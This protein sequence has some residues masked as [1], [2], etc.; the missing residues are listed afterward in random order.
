VIRCALH[1]T[2]ARTRSNPICVQPMEAVQ[3]V[4]NV[5][6]NKYVNGKATSVR[7]LSGVV[8]TICGT[9]LCV[10]FGSSD[11]R[12]FDL[13]ELEAFWTRP[14]WWTYLALSYSVATAAHCVHEAY[15]RAVAAGRRPAHAMHVMP[16]TF[17]VSSALF[18]GSQMIVHSKAVAEIFELQVQ[19]IPPQPLGHYFFYVELALLSCTGVYWLVRMNTS[20]GLYDPLFII[21][22]LQSACAPRPTSGNTTQAFALFRVARTLRLRFLLTASTYVSPPPSPCSP[23]PPPRS[24]LAASLLD[25]QVYPLRGG[26]WRHFL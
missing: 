9:L 13:A 22:L 3:F 16:V 11:A 8:L 20:L 2:I 10:I 24:P 18:G 17:A 6:F 15:A 21:P 23:H 25:C 4:V 5:A 26:Q 7:M 19:L 1:L 12:C 14:L